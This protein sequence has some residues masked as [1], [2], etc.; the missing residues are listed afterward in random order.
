MQL[1]E[2]INRILAVAVLVSG[3]ANALHW[4]GRAGEKFLSVPK[5]GWAMYVFFAW[6]AIAAIS[7]GIARAGLFP[8]NMAVSLGVSSGIALMAYSIVQRH[9]QRKHGVAGHEEVI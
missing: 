9:N 4:R 7:C 5:S 3:V 8:M 2:T 1:F 6:F